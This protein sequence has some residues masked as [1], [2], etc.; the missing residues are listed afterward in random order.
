MIETNSLNH[1][2]E[3]DF[4]TESEILGQ[5]D[6][7]LKLFKDFQSIKC[8]LKNYLDKILD[9]KEIRIILTGAG[10]SAFIGDVLLGAFNKSFQNPVSAIPTTD[11]ITHPE[12]YLNKSNKYLLISFARSGNSPESSQAILLT[13]D[14]SKQTYHILITC[15]NESDLIKTVSGKNHFTFLMPPEADD[16]GL[17][18]TGSFTT[19]LLAGLLITR[20]Y[21]DEDLEGQFN[22][23]Y[24]YGNKILN[25]YAKDIKQVTTYDFKRA[26][27]LGSGMLK[28]IARESHLKLQELTDGKVI[29][30]YDSFMGFRHGP[31][32]IVGEDTLIAYLFSNN[33]HVNL[34][35]VDL[36]NANVSG[37][38]NLFSIGI[39]EQEI[40]VPGIDLQ[41]VLSDN[42]KNIQEDFLTVVSVLPAQLLGF[43]K[44]LNLGLNPDSPS[45]SGM[46]HRVVQGVKI[47]PYNNGI[48]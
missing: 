41:I 14:L 4:F 19:M 7:W 21:N 22:L 11:L 31:K 15:N 32:A 20:I 30:K 43:Y 27:F 46:I 33:K 29:C 44:S 28:G 26:V 6:L 10:T 38:K 9:D 8:D 39:M 42:G 3:S 37:R 16:R 23:L 34:Y 36:V 5:P 12:L 45:K 2:L 35:E 18:M 13:E 40:K 47:Y 48:E 1:L 24:T 25:E 17:A